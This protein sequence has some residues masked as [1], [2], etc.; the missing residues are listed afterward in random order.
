MVHPQVTQQLQIPSIT[1]HI[2]GMLHP[3]VTQQLLIPSITQ[4][5]SGMHP[6]LDGH[7]QQP[8]GTLP[9]LG[10]SPQH[11]LHFGTP[12]GMILGAV[13]QLLIGGVV[14]LLIGM[15]LGGVAQLLIGGVVPLLIG[16]LLGTPAQ[17]LIITLHLCTPTSLLMYRVF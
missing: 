3:Q 4:H 2:T 16:I 7:Q 9:L 8:T 13:V 5:I 1:Q 10:G 17:Q 12:L 15:R 6:Q 11:H 14:P